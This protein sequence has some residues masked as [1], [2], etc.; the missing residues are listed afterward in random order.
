MAGRC[1]GLSAQLT[2][3][4][5]VSP[6]A[7]LSGRAIGLLLLSCDRFQPSLTDVGCCCDHI[8]RVFKSG[9]FN[10]RSALQSN[11]FF[12]TD[13]PVLRAAFADASEKGR[14]GKSQPFER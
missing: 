12:E 10:A 7:P 13:L 8:S 4:G 3:Q 6:H 14:L 5:S 1:V 9:Q 2:K 11:P